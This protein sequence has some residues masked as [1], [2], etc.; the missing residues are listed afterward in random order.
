IPKVES[1][2]H[3]IDGGVG[4]AHILDGRVA[5]VTLLELL[6]DTGVGTMFIADEV[7]Q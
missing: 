3:A 2:M 5:H 1:C 6:T 4:A 7:S